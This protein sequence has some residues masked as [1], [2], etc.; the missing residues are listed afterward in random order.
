MGGPGIVS[1]GLYIPEKV[2]DYEQIGREFEIPPDVVL[3]KQGLRKKHISEREEMPSDMAF[4]AASEAI[5]QYTDGGFSKD[6]IHAIIYVGSQWKDYNLWLISTRL[7]E[8]LGLRKAY[9][10]DM[11]AMCAGM[12]MGL[13]LSKGMLLANKEL[14]A[15]L[16][17]GASKESYIVNP[18]NKSTSWM[19]DF[20]DAGVAAIVQK[21]ADRNVILESD[22]FTDG[23]L[24]EAALIVPGGAKNPSFERYC[25]LNRPYIDSLVPKE[26]FK[27]KMEAE[28]LGNFRNV[29]E[30]SVKKSGL[31][32]SDIHMVFLNHMKPSFHRNLIASL[33]ID[34]RRSIYLEEFGHSQSADQFIG[35]R[36][37]LEEK[38]LV[39]GNIVF[40]AA[41]TGYVWGSTVIRW[42]RA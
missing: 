11:S 27:R 40:A 24:S 22:F 30:R 19:D 16:L 21:D 36:I 6:D 31:K 37:A 25:D 20:A 18:S 17:V 41:G 1:F 15:V 8:L 38:R 28:S 4:H 35:L 13:N 2:V 29:I 23:S 5:R 12:V 14:E 26:E 7:Q 9:S 32:L 10:F 3:N 34:P 39:E 33:G 42:G